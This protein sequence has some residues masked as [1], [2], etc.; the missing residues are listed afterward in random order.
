MDLVQYGQYYNDAM[1]GMDALFEDMKD[2]MKNFNKKSYPGYFENMMKKYG[3][4]FLC[5]EAVY[6]HEDT[7]EKKEKFLRKLADRFIGY[8]EEMV[9]SKKWKFQKQSTLIDCNMF[10]VSYVLPAINGFEGNMAKP[11]AQILC[12][13]WNE[14]FG[15]NMEVGDYDRI[16]NGFSTSIFG[17]KIGK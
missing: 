12:D 3:K 10:V 16:Y 9:S 1:A 8:A 14:K 2:S 11:F 6:D 5:I 17:I 7:E 4:V 15:T 13:N